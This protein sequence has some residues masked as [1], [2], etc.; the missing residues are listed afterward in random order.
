MKRC[1]QRNKDGG[2]IML[3]LRTESQGFIKANRKTKKK[4][5]GAE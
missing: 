2:N 5:G 1:K 3:Y 4:R